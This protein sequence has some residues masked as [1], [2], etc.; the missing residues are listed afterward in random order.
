VSVDAQTRELLA[1]IAAGP[2]R[3]DEAIERWRTSCPRLSV[4]DDAV[5]DGLVRIVRE[6]RPAMVVLT[7]GGRDA[8]DG[9][10]AR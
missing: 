4:W 3:Y 6:P 7:P 9:T 1:W 2:R 5:S 8:L 10:H